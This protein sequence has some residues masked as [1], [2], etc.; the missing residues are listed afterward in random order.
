MGF[1][2]HIAT[3]TNVWCLPRLRSQR[4]STPSVTPSQPADLS[5]A[6]QRNVEALAT[7]QAAERDT[8]PFRDRI[9]AAITGFTGS[10]AF[11]YLHLAVYGLWIA[12]NLG[13]VP[14]ISP[15]DPTFVILAS[16]ASVEAIFLSTFV[17]INQNRM[18]ATANKRADL[19]LHIS[20]LTEHEL[21]KLAGLI[22]AMAARMGIEVPG[23]EIEEIK[24]DVAPETVLDEL[25]RRAVDPDKRD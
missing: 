19:D 22:A 14:G 24:R 2:D 16:E 7:R 18:A 12:I 1:I 5:G 15:F 3:P 21:T 10:M 13:W 25:E 4:I 8:A 20:L 23:N 11:V 17:L 9:A 6:L